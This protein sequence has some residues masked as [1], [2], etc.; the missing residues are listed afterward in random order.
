MGPTNTEINWTKEHRHQPTSSEQT[1][2]QRREHPYLCATW[3]PRLLTGENSCEWAGWF[4]AHYHGWTRT[5]TEFDHAQWLMLH[6]ELIHDH[7]SQWEDRGY[8]VSVEDQT[9]FGS[10]A[11]QHRSSSV[12]EKNGC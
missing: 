10:K 12:S 5:P 4:K 11:H 8:A 1:L 2:A 7:R 3:L 9:A 6:T